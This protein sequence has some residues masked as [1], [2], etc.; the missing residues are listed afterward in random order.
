MDIASIAAAAL[1][2]DTS[3]AAILKVSGMGGERV[4]EWYRTLRLGAYTMDVLSLVIGAYIAMRIAPGSL[5]RQIVA[6][7]IVQMVHDLAF[8]AFVRSP[9]ARGP[10]MDLF[11]RYAAEMG[12]HILWADAAMMVATVLT[13]HMLSRRLSTPDTAFVGAAAAYVGLLVVYSF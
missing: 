9:A 4:R 12:V 3:T 8:G 10:L 7:V 5:W 13:A 11:R 6:V 2:V 1:V